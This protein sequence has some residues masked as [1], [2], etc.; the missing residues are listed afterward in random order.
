MELNRKTVDELLGLD[1]NALR[2]KAEKVARAAGMSGNLP[3]VSKIRAM[4]SGIGDEDIRRLVSMLGKERTE[5]MIREIQ[6]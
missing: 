2:E 1:D 4:L 6:G 3:D 5:Q